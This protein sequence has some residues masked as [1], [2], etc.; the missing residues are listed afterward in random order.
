[1][2]RAG[3]DGPVLFHKSGVRRCAN[4]SLRIGKR[5]V[6]D[7]ALSGFTLRPDP[8]AVATDDGMRDGKADAVPLNF[9]SLCRR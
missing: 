4:H 9:A 2:N 7:L 3:L 8:S 1:M 6:E 5:E